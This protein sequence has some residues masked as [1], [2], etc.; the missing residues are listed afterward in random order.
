[1]T[2]AT[3]IDPVTVGIVTYNSVRTICG[4]LDSLIAADP[5]A[6][7]T[8][9]V[10]DNGSRDG[11]PTLLAAYAQRD[12][13]IHLLGRAD[14]IGFGRGHNEILRS[15]AGSV[16]IICNPD[17]VVGQDFIDRSLAFLADYPDVGLMSPRMIDS[18]G[19]LQ[20]SNRRHPT[21]LD[22]ALRR[23]A[24]RALQSAF[25]RRM[26]R[27]E[28]ADVGYQSIYDVPFCSGALM[29]CRRQALFDVGGFDDR[30]FLYFEDADL[31]RMM[32][33]AG[34]RTVFNPAVEVTHGWQR[35]GHRSLRLAG[36][37]TASAFR[38][39]AKWGWR[40]F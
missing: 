2:A 17:I 32:Q 25:A 11:T 21:V 10:R 19:N 22:L 35:G 12:K 1:M 31:S 8:I 33:Q 28:M 27:Y 16:H 36:V 13:R 7:A 30:Y 38:Y 6:A 15:N 26:E 18:G 24:P 4:T 14:N 3:S 37:M 40:L 39:F 20:H 5:S 9:F 23:F 34:W 29:V